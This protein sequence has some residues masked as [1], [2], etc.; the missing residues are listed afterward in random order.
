MVGGSFGKSMLFF[1]PL[2]SVF[3]KKRS[4][5]IQVSNEKYLKWKEIHF[6]F[7]KGTCLA[8]LIISGIISAASN[9]IPLV[10]NM[11]SDVVFWKCTKKQP[12]TYHSKTSA[13]Q[14]VS[15]PT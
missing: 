3:C 11:S 5:F 8:S 1:L 2:N 7:Y 13:T 10:Q 12:G 4:I 15:P 6:W 9:S 14:L